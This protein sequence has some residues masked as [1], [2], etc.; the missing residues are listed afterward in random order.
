[1]L[2]IH[3]HTARIG[4]LHDP[5]THQR[6]IWRLW[7]SHVRV[8]ACLHVAV[9]G[10]FRMW[11]VCSR[12]FSNSFS[13]SWRSLVHSWSLRNCRG[14]TLWCL[15]LLQPLLTIAVASGLMIIWFCNRIILLINSNIPSACVRC[16]WAIRDFVWLTVLLLFW[17]EGTDWNFFDSID[18]F[19]RRSHHVV[20]STIFRDSCHF[21]LEASF[22]IHFSTNPILL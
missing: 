22:E 10:L 20:Y 6:F 5:V 2:R 16:C 18:R 1:M 14:R 3:H 15:H 12:T 11:V 7:R 17:I 19:L 21:A 13:D 8:G 4:L 9:E